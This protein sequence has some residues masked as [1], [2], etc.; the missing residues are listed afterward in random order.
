M[1]NQPGKQQQPKHPTGLPIVAAQQ[2]THDETTVPSG[3]SARRGVQGTPGKANKKCMRKPIYLE[4]KALPG[5]ISIAAASLEISTHMT[6]SRPRRYTTTNQ[7][8]IHDT[9]HTTP[10]VRNSLQN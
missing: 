1:C 3:Y 2:E 8:Y 9:R 6:C 4:H 5:Y 10:A 7:N